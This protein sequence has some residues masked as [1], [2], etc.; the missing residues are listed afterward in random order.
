[1]D[2]TKAQFLAEAAPMIAVIVIVVMAAWV[3]TTWLRIKNGY[4]LD[5]GMGGAH[6]PKVDRETKD[7]IKLLNQE[8]AQLRDELAGLKN[9]LAS[10]E[11]I[12]T[13]RGYGLDQEIERLRDRA[14]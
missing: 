13:D 6:H 5:D 14:E 4:P 2:P 10:V 11:T 1:M 7:Q 12:V 3:G 9:R 8:N